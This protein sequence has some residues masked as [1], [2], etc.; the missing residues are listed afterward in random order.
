MPR[1]PSKHGLERKY[2]SWRRGKSKTAKASDK[3]LSK[4]SLKNQL[5]SHQRFLAK[6]TDD[7]LRK[8]VLETIERVKQEIVVKEAK[9]REKDNASKSHGARFLERQKL[10]RLEAQAR[11]ELEKARQTKGATTSKDDSSTINE[12]LF[13]I[14]LDQAYVA[15]Y[16]HEIKYQPLFRKGGRIVDNGRTVV[17]RAITRKRCLQ[18]LHP[19][20]GWI[21]NDQYER[22]PDEWSVE[23]EKQVFGYQKTKA[24]KTQN[25]SEGTNDSRF[26]FSTNQDKM[27][28]TVDQIESKLLEEER[29]QTKDD[30]EKDNDS[31]N[32]TD[33]ADPLLTN[34]AA[35]DKVDRNKASGDTTSDSESDSSDDNDKEDQDDDASSS[36]S[37]D[38]DTSSSSNDDSSSSSGSS[39]DSS[40]DDSDQDSSS[41]AVV[42][43]KTETQPQS[44]DKDDRD[45][46]DEPFDDFFTPAKDDTDAFANA[47]QDNSNRDFAKGD[48]SMGWATQRQRPGEWKK[49]RKRT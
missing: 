2:K 47:R 39:S 17:W 5:R 43:K 33:E 38:D 16:P 34:G 30:Q 1:L 35:R 15:H 6:V 40:D 29:A 32:S 36:S 23:L 24:K 14:A 9:E 28:Q 44:A 25:G 19:R 37:S 4:T 48:K 13:R 22:L 10:V 3:P 26:T 41:Q 42:K 45:K 11:K 31:D 27:V 49:K 18:N 21:S 12:N 8:E 20:V 7:K 46:D